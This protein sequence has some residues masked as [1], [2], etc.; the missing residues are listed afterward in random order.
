M[1]DS[2]QHPILQRTHAHL[3]LLEKMHASNRECVLM[4]CNPTDQLF[5]IH[6]KSN[7]PQPNTNA[8]TWELLTAVVGLHLAKFMPSAVKGNTNC[9]S[10]I[11]RL[12]DAMLAF[13]DTQSTIKAG[14]LISGGYQF[15]AP[16]EDTEDITMKLSEIGDPRH[17]S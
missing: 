6:I 5:V 9:I 4:P 2:Q 7:K 10:A 16:E 1:I 8:Y 17:I 11:I 14:V 12:N 3:L 15:R 13:H